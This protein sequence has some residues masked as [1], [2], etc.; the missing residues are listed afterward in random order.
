MRITILST[1]A[2]I[3]SLLTACQ[4]QNRGEK[5]RQITDTLYQRRHETIMK[6]C[7][8]VNKGIKDTGMIA[9]VM[10]GAQSNV[11]SVRADVWRRIQSDLSLFTK[12]GYIDTS[13]VTVDNFQ[14]LPENFYM[15]TNEPD[16][17]PNAYFV[18][19]PTG[20]D[21]YFLFK[22]GKIY[23]FRVFKMGSRYIFVGY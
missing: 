8:I 20:V 9:Q 10:V 12:L 2:W 11:D 17:L 5:V 21:K 23:S 16:I 18:S 4:A 22:G 15:F 14:T 6:F 3:V 1:L 13:K 19:F 7:E